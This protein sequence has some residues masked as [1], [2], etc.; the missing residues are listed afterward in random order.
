MALLLL[1]ERRK[2]QR[3]R[4]W[5]YIQQVP[6]TVDLPVRWG[7]AELAQLQYQPAIQE[8]R[9]RLICCMLCALLC[10]WRYG[11]A[12]LVS[13]GVMQASFEAEGH[14]Y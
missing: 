6:P 1:E 2:G 8:V 9:A 11:E 14:F 5:G 7:E 10:A 3:S 4:L 12:T 13:A